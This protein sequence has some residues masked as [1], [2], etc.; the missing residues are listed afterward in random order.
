MRKI[1]NLKKKKK[2]RNNL[3]LGKDRGSLNKSQ[4]LKIYKAPETDSKFE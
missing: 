3:S 1:P 4:K 2:K